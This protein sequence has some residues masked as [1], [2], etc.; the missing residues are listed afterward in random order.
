MVVPSSAHVAFDKAAQYLGVRLT[1][2]PVGCPTFRADVH[3][4]ARAVSRHTIVVAGSSPGFPHGVIDPIPALS[5]MARERG[6]RLPHRRLPRRFRAAVGRAARLRGAPVRLPPPRRDLDV[7]R[8]SQVRV[9]GE[10]NIGGAV[11]RPRPAPPSVLDRHG[12]ARR[13]LLLADPGGEPARGSRRCSLGRDVVDGGGRV[14]AGHRRPARNRSARSAPGSRRSTA[15]RVLGDPLWVI[16]F[17]SD[18][19]DIYEVMSRM[20][21]R[22]WSLNGLHHPPAVHIAVTLRHTRPGVVGDVPGGPG[23]GCGGGEGDRRRGD[24]SRPR[25]TAWPPPSPPAAPSATSSNATSTANT[26]CERG[27]PHPTRR[28]PRRAATRYAGIS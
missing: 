27:S 24:R 15:S 22:G 19:V 8:H 7:G 25:S 23:C 20:A 4:M 6:S 14:P 2:V 3:A 10:G 17:S 12:V 16:A 13:A 5:E 18:T 11:P 9:C 1:K 21:Q 26:K 28:L